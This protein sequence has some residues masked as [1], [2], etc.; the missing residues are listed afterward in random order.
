MKLFDLLAVGG[1]LKYMRLSFA[2]FDHCHY[3][4]VLNDAMLIE[5]ALK[6]EISRPNFSFNPF[7]NYIENNTIVHMLTLFR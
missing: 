2:V 1:Y 5:S 3:A 6:R 7:I 4:T